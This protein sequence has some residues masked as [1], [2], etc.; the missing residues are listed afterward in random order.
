MD[1]IGPLSKP[2]CRYA[3]I[4]IKVG[5]AGRLRSKGKKMTAHAIQNIRTRREWA[6]IITFQCEKSVDDIIEIGRELV[7]AFDELSG[8]E[9]KKIVQQDLPFGIRT[10]R[11]LRRIAEHPAIGGAAP[12]AATRASLPL[13]VRPESS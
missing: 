4:S 7:G 11:Y 1:T 2:Q 10:A 13:R 8:S 12:G 5:E 3:Q 9:Y 6:E